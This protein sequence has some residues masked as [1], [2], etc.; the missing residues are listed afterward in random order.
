MVSFKT[1]IVD[2]DFISRKLIME[3]LRK[4]IYSVD[5]IESVD[6]RDAIE[7]V[8]SE[9]DID[10]IILDIEL[11]KLN[12]IDFLDIYSGLDVKRSPII[13]ISSKSINTDSVIDGRVNAFVHKPI[14]K[15]KLLRA[16]GNLYFNI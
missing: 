3:I 16:I 6:S 15:D 4:N 12:G 2:S 8:K 10:L 11:P 5:I 7:I 1:L 9:D 14:T 13:A